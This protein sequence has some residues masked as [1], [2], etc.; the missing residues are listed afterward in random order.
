MTIGIS[1]ETKTPLVCFVGGCGWVG[2][3]HRCERPSVV[4]V[5]RVSTQHAERGAAHCPGATRAQRGKAPSST[6]T[7][8][9]LNFDA[10]PCS[11]VLSSGSGSA[12]NSVCHNTPVVSLTKRQRRRLAPALGEETRTPHKV[13]GLGDTHIQRCCAPHLSLPAARPPP[14]FQHREQCRRRKM[15]L[16][17]AA[18]CCTRTTGTRQCVERFSLLVPCSAEPIT[19]V[20]RAGLPSAAQGVREASRCCSVSCRAERCTYRVT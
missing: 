7:A 13:Y 6:C 5:T 18:G 4:L 14:F 16:A 12:S 17:V 1:L 8:E 10:A 20:G 15:H 3:R 2:G 9:R 11:G 19:A